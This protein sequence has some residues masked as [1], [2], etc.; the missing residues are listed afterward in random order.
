MQHGKQVGAAMRS[1]LGLDQ[2]HG[3]HAL[4]G[5]TT[6]EAAENAIYDA[7]KKSKF[8]DQFV[9]PRL[10]DLKGG[11]LIEYKIKKLRDLNLDPNMRSAQLNDQ[12]Y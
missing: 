8:Y 9:K 11:E 10:Q 3:V 12:R 1:K 7:L 4:Y 5:N 2:W 6:T